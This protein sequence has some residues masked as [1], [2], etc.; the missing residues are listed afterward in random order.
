[1]GELERSLEIDPDILAVEVKITA[2]VQDEEKVRRYLERSGQEPQH[3]QVYF[4]DTSELALFDGGVVLRARK[5][6]DDADD[7]TV[8]LRPVDPTNL[9]VAWKQTKD[10]V[11]ELDQVGDNTICS[12]KLSSEQKREEIDEVA[13][14]EREIRKLFSAVQEQLIEEH[15]PTSVTWEDLRVLGPVEVLKWKIDPKGF[16]EEVTA[17]QWTLPD[18]SDLIEL[19]IKV[20]PEEAGDASGEFLSFLNE[21]GFTTEGDQQ[22]KTRG[23]LTYFTE[24]IGFA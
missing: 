15:A 10:F 8:K 23:A 6:T 5:I 11:I 19:S 14:G 7:S 20:K 24:G 4:F 21:N 9:S 17:E 12:A 13:A 16:G 1:M 22:T 18:R 3:R 2:Q